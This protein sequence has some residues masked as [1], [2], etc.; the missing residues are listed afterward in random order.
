MASLAHAATAAGVQWGLSPAHSSASAG[1]SPHRLS[2]LPRTPISGSIRH[3]L[4]GDALCFRPLPIGTPKSKLA[5]AVRN[6]VAT[7][8][9]PQVTNKK[10]SLRSDI[11]NIAIV[12]HVDHGKTTLVDAMLRQAKV[13]RDNQSVQERIMDS[14][15][16]ERERGITILSKNTAIRYKGTKINIIDTPGHSDFGGEVERVL[17]MVDGVLLLVDS[18][19]GPMPQTRFVLK[20]A[21]ELGQTVVVVV[22]KVDRPSARPDYVVNTTFELFVELNA[23][24]EQCDFQVVY[25]SGI[26]GKAG[27]E[28]D[29]LADDLEPLFEAVIRCIPEPRVDIEGPLQ[30]LITNLDYDEHKGRIAIGRVH[31]GRV[32]KGMEVKVCTPDDRCRN[33]KVN[34]LFEYDNFARVP[35]DVV[36][37]GDICCLSG[38]DDVLIGETLADKIDG[39]AL[40][41]ITVEE[42]TVRMSFSV[43]TSPFAGREG[44]YVTSRNLRDRLYRELERNLAMKVEDGETADT[45]IVSGRGTLHLTILIENMRREGYEFLIGPPK[46]INREL[47]GKKL[48]PFEDAT[49]EVP[50]E[51]VGAVVD[52]M[53][54]RRGQM[55]DLSTTGMENT[56]LVKYRIPTRGLLGLRNAILTASRG[57]AVLNTIFHGYDVWAGDISTRE[58][59]SLVAFETGPTTS[60][61][62]FSCQDRGNL[63]L[64]PGVEVYKGQIIGIHQ[65]PG[66]LSLNACKRKA[67]TN[68]RSNKE[69]TVVLASPI[70]LSLDDCVEYIQ[71]D[72]LVEVTPLSIRMCKNAK[73]LQKKR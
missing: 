25:A 10:M 60:Y 73:M 48:E 46:V 27:L 21:L 19:E 24:D 33:V 4:L 29:Q 16:L 59:G 9:L 58:Q 17:N 47:N 12:A 23:S 41:T 54:K 26:H 42:P 34:E 68:V 8:E 28:P 31:A 39:V 71:E 6:A 37:A 5:A 63:F 45:F 56:T 30:M 51:Y 3:E 69:A 18:V 55:L 43:N 66:D 32:R 40:P 20:K 36:E 64:G 1:N 52:L 61:A 65:R 50:E 2:A 72:E 44:K 14:N 38:I 49:V 62:L 13:F 11:R 70:E 15:D 35:A 22:N 53:G 57:T 67:A 7:E